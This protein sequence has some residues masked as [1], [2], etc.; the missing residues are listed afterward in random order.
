MN[1]FTIKS[2]TFLRTEVTA[3]YNTHYV[4]Y[5][6]PNNPDFLNT[7]KNTYDSFCASSLNSAE[8]EVKDVLSEDLPLVLKNN[9]LSNA[10]V[11]VIP[12]AKSHDSYSSDQLRFRKAV[13]DTVCEYANLV[14]GTEWVKRK[15]NTKTTHLDGRNVPNY[16]N[17]GPRPYTGIT[18][19]TCDF[20]EEI[21]GKD[22][23]LVDDIYTSNVNI[24]EDA[25]QALLD[26]GAKSVVL[27]VVAKTRTLFH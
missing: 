4:G 1:K 12:R 7:L 2:N 19:D 26:F 24:D 11:C 25:I 27:Y 8:S 3:F 18:K 23:I 16:C 13:K 5:R 21:I 10:V 9:S 15:V 6:R 17:D 22:I 14:D 20:S